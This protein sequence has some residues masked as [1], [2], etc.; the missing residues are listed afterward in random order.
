MPFR[1]L[2]GRRKLAE[3]LHE[4]DIITILNAEEDLSLQDS[5]SEVED[6]QII[7]VRSKRRRK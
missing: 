6:N 4:D 1:Q 3:R 2:S 5:D 7:E